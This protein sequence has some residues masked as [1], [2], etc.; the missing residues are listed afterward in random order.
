MA[1]TLAEI[2]QGSFNLIF[3]II[4]IIVGIKI[5]T[6][7]VENKNSDFILVGITWIGISTPWMHG[8]IAFVLLFFNI[9]LMEEIR[10]IIGYVFIPVIT[11]LWLHVFTNFLH[12]E[13]KKL[14]L[15]LYAII[16][17]VCEILFFTFLVTN[18][19]ALI[20]YFE[21]TF[22]AVYRPFVRFTLL[23]FLA[24]ALI[25]FLLF[26]K[27]SLKSGDAEVRLKGKF[28]IVAFLTYV[29]CAIL[30]S[31]FLFD[32][33]TVVLVRLFLISS[34]IEFYFGWIMPDWLKRR[35]SK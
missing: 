33:V 19:V 1:L 35:L 13:K 25:T 18:R 16:C 8:A 20:G 10:F 15:L 14:I 11:V 32:P 7:Y 29:A 17:L 6:K 24:T 21:R 31:F 27:Q 23:F 22:S 30:D 9:I 3:V 5:M 34:A 28:L 2:F 26:A 12:K 4:S